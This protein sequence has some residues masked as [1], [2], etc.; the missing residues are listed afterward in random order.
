MSL[1]HDRPEQTESTYRQL[2]SPDA[3]RYLCLSEKYKFFELDVYIYK[4][5]YSNLNGRKGS[6]NNLNGGNLRYFSTNW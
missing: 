3:V 6:V 4:S 5:L 1:A 2:D